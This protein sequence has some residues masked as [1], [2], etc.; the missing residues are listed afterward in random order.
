MAHVRCRWRYARKRKRERD[1]ESLF[2][3]FFFVLASPV[4]TVRAAGGRLTRQLARARPIQLND[5]PRLNPCARVHPLERACI[6]DAESHKGQKQRPWIATTTAREGNS[7]FLG[8]RARRVQV[9]GSRPVR[10]AP[11]SG[12]RPKTSTSGF[13]PERQRMP[14]SGGG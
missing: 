12:P 11:C 6:G 4:R 13:Q 9:Q 3:D 5:L 1:R 8:C 2:S 10:P 7:F 14:L